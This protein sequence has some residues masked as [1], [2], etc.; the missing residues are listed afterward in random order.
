M[1]KLLRS[2]EGMKNITQKSKCTCSCMKK[3]HYKGK[4]WDWEMEDKSGGDV[5]T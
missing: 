5:M 1:Y 4:S 2:K 3:P